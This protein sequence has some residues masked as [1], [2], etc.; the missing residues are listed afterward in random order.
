MFK[1]GDIPHTKRPT[2]NHA[3]SELIEPLVDET[4][5]TLEQLLTAVCGQS[6]EQLEGFDPSAGT[7]G[8]FSRNDALAPSGSRMT[9][10]VFTWTPPAPQRQEAAWLHPVPFEMKLNATS[11]NPKEWVVSEVAFFGRPPMVVCPALA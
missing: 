11:P 4:I 5:Q 10:A 6:F 9:I 7:V 2:E 1:L 8:W 3:D